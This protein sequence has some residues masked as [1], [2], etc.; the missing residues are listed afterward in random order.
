MVPKFD[1]SVRKQI[2]NER[3]I[4]SIDTG[5]S[6]V[7]SASFSEDTG[8][9]LENIVY[10]LLRNQHRDIYYFSGRHECDFVIRIKADKYFL[11]QVCLELSPDNIDREINGLMEAMDYL[12]CRDGIIVTLTQKDYLE[13]NGTRIPAIPFHEFSQGYEKRFA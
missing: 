2:S 8:R 4:Y 9:K 5:L 12:H 6:T 3:K 1:F 13:K 10:L 7:N 11:V